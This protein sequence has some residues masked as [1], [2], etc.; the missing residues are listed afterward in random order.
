[1][2]TNY[3]Y[4]EGTLKSEIHVGEFGEKHPQGPYLKDHPT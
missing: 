1:M 4:I 3:I 2:K